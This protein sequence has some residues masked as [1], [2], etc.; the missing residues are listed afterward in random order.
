MRPAGY[1]YQSEFAREYF[2]QGKAEGH[3][4][5]L[6]AILGARG[7]P[8]TKADRAQIESCSDV[9]KLATMTIRALTAKSP[10]DI[11]ADA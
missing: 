7:I 9:A 11:F 4:D 1:E 5:A 2:G 8:L 10:A 6:L 3:R